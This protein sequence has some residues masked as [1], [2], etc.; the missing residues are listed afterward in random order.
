MGSWLGAAPLAEVLRVTVLAY[1]PIDA[2]SVVSYNNTAKATS[3]LAV[4][5]MGDCGKQARCNWGRGR[6]LAKQTPFRATAASAI[7]PQ[8]ERINNRAKTYLADQ[9]KR[10]MCEFR[11]KFPKLAERLNRHWS[12]SCAGP[13]SRQPSRS[14]EFNSFELKPQKLLAFFFLSR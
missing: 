9:A 4:R 12:S 14:P 7:A 10:R 5:R 3:P 8:E 11:S 13:S 1:H 6:Y 2:S